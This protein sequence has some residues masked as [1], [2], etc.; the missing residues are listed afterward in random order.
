MTTGNQG[1]EFLHGNRKDEFGYKKGYL[2]D[3]NRFGAMTTER[4]QIGL[5]LKFTMMMDEVNGIATNN[6]SR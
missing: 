1:V 6:E 3:R 2:S 5:I 4:T